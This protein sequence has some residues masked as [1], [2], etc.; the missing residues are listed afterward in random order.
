VELAACVGFDDFQ[1]YPQPV[2]SHDAGE[3]GRKLG[4]FGAQRLSSAIGGISRLDQDWSNLRIERR[5]IK[6]TVDV[7]NLVKRQ[8]VDPVERGWPRAL[9]HD[10]V[11]LGSCDVI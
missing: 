9:P 5:D 6:A 7:V 10:E 2:A 8:A 4:D 3:N 1:P 11:D